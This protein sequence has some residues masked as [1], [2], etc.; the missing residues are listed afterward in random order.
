MKTRL[1]YP[2]AF[3]AALL[4]LLALAASLPARAQSYY[5][6]YDIGTFVLDVTDGGQPGRGRDGIWLSLSTGALFGPS[7]LAGGDIG[8][9]MFRP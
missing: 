5:N 6:V 8:L 9:S 4:A 3:P 7:T 1:R 2:A